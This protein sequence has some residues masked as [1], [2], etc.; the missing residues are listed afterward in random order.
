MNM[1]NL[2]TCLAVGL[3]FFCALNGYTACLVMILCVELLFN[4]ADTKQDSDKAA[5]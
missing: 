1:K 3:G 5:N 4:K 2:Q